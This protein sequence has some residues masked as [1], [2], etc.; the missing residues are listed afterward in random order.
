MNLAPGKRDLRVLPRK[1]VEDLLLDGMEEQRRA[2]FSSTAAA[3]VEEDD[4]LFMHGFRLDDERSGVRVHF[5][6]MRSRRV[7][8]YYCELE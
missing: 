2:E 4:G 1:A 3:A 7:N 5:W 8:C 6:L